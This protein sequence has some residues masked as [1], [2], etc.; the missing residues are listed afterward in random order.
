MVNKLI[1]IGTDA[2]S[3]EAVVFTVY[4]KGNMTKHITL[5]DE[6]LVPHIRWDTLEVHCASKGEGEE[7]KKYYNDKMLVIVVVTEENNNA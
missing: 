5:L 7:I 3:R 1:C 6:L 4:V 2:T